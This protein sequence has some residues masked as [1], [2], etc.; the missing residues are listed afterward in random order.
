MGEERR[1]DVKKHYDFAAVYL[2]CSVQEMQV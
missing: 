2:C 1:I